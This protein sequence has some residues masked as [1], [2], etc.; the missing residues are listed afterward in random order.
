MCLLSLY[1]WNPLT[2]SFF[3]FFALLRTLLFMNPADLNTINLYTQ[4]LPGWST[5]RRSS[6]SHGN[7][8]A[9]SA[10]RWTLTH[11][12]HQWS[13]RKTVILSEWRRSVCFKDF[14]YLLINWVTA[15]AATLSGLKTENLLIFQSVSL[16]RCTSPFDLLVSKWDKWLLFHICG[17]QQLKRSVFVMLMLLECLQ[18]WFK[19]KHWA[20]EWPSLSRAG[21]LNHSLQHLPTHKTVLSL[22]H[23]RNV[24]SVTESGGKPI[25]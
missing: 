14:V 24:A 2:A 9:S 19:R 18:S 5:C 13:G 22:R 15:S 21:G 23:R 10:A 11:L 8:Q 6:T 1:W 16:R 17:L 7:C 25:T 4:T 3:F 20:A 12:W